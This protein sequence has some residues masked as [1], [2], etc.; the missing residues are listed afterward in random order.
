MVTSSSSRLNLALIGFLLSIALL[1]SVYA[2]WLVARGATSQLEFLLL[3]LLVIF[4]FL[5]PDIGAVLLPLVVALPKGDYLPFGLSPTLVVLGVC[6][7]AISVRYALR[8]LPR[9][10]LHPVTGLLAGLSAFALLTTVIG[11]GPEARV[12]FWNLGPALPAFVIGQLLV[13]NERILERLI[14]SIEMSGL[15]LL[16]G[17]TY[18]TLFGSQQQALLA[19][20]QYLL[21]RRWDFDPYGA[22]GNWLSLAIF[23]L[24]LAFIRI[25]NGGHRLRVLMAYVTVGGVLFLSTL[26]NVRNGWILL[27]LGFLLTLSLRLP[28]GAGTGRRIATICVLAAIV[29]LTFRYVPISALGNML[30]RIQ[31]L[32]SLEAPLNRLHWW[33]EALRLIVARPLLGWGPGVVGN[34]FAHNFYMDAAINYG[35]PYSLGWIAALVMVMR[36]TRRALAWP[37]PLE[38]RR[39]TAGLWVASW[40]SLIYNLAVSAL[41][42]DPFFNTIF[43]LCAGVVSKPYLGQD[44]P[45]AARPWTDARDPQPI[46]LGAYKP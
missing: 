27:C 9:H 5:R 33:P 30:T 7:A 34:Y 41:L 38:L 18:I 11:Y 3:L 29:T 24:A 23:P 13:T 19:S 31:Q 17:L 43:W 15:L 39:A 2:G 10:S 6:F 46:S 26:Y 25:L 12:L 32:V 45:M 40:L 16:G 42:G 21:L 4:L 8:R 28:M 14:L 44:S 22:D 37:G 35:I 1:G 36:G 20:G